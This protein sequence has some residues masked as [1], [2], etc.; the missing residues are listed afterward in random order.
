MFFFPSPDFL[1]A[2]ALSMAVGTPQDDCENEKNIIQKQLPSW[3]VNG[4][5]APLKVI[6]MQLI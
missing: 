5:F 6:V 2:T 1:K 4:N 3:E